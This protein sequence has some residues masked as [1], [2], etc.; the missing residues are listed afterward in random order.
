MYELVRI[1]SLNEIETFGENF[2]NLEFLELIKSI[3]VNRPTGWDIKWMRRLTTTNTREQG[4]AI[5]LCV[6]ELRTLWSTGIVW[7]S[8][9]EPRALL[10]APLRKSETTP[11]VPTSH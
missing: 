2:Q 4:S 7:R 3:E 1:L 9:P 6:C 8:N 10:T 11:P 5:K